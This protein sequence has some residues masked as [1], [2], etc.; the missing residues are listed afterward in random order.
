MADGS[1]VGDVVAL[2]RLAWSLAR[3]FEEAKTRATGIAEFQEIKLEADDLSEALRL[4]A[5]TINEDESYVASP[6]CVMQEQLV[7]AVSSTR[8]ALED[9]DSVI[10][11]YK[12]MKKVET[13][14]GFNIK[15]DWSDAVLAN[16][17]TVSW[18]RSQ[19]DISAALALLHAHTNIILLTNTRLQRYR[20]M[21]P[22]SVVLGTILKRPAVNCPKVSLYHH[23]HIDLLSVR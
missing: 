8:E 19:G 18:T 3:E 5:E 20:N 7:T 4:L 16:Y 1:S 14:D 15:R 17:K 13:N 11:R 12:V 6:G 9:L 22:A 2:S 10:D 23:Q 21:W